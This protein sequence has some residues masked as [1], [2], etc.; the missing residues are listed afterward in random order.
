MALIDAEGLV[1]FLLVA[2]WLWALIDVIATD[3]SRA[4]NLPKG[5]WLL[6]VLLF[7]DV[8]SLCWLLFGR[9]QGAGIWPGGASSGGGGR[10]QP[11]YRGTPGYRTSREPRYLGEYDISDRRSAQLDAALDAHLERRET[12]TT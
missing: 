10:P 12:D 8:G 11:G 4:R 3:S 7:L 9:P 5:V 2:F 1:L 6:L